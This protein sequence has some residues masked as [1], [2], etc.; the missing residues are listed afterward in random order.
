MAYVTLIALKALISEPDLT[1]ALDDDADG[2]I[3][4]FDTVQA[5]ADGAVDALL[6]LRYEVPFIVDAPQI[7]LQ[8]AKIFAAELCFKRRNVSDE[9][10]PWFNTA[11]QMR[12]MLAK[13]ASG[14][15]P[16]APAVERAKP[17]GTLISENSAL[18]SSG[19]FRI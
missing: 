7:C 14:E 19:G 9:L 15:L 8:A 2:V 10:N 13:I 17:S 1:K 18:Y 16:L 6:S 12:K 11:E 4:A 3:D 5:Q